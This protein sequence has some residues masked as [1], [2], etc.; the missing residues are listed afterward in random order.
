MKIISKE[1]Y[2]ALQKVRNIKL[3]LINRFVL[4]CCRTKIPFLRIFAKCVFHVELP[5]KNDDI[6]M[7][8]PFSVVVN[9]HAIIGKNVT[10]Y[11]GVTIGEK[12]FGTSKGVP[13]LG[14]DVIVYPN[15]VI[16]GGVVIGHRAVIGAGAVVTK[17][18]SEGSVVAGN[19]AKEIMREGPAY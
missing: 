14:D 17:N 9:S 18:V 1:D 7:G 13:T 4:W 5:S 2:L 11:H 19:P 6:R 8:H 16:V 15:A 10:L 12:I 3:G